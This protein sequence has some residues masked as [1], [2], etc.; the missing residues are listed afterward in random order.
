[1]R[2]QSDAALH[3]DVAFDFRRDTPEGKDPDTH[4]KRLRRYHQLL[5]SKRLPGGEIFE[6]EEY[7]R[8]LRYRSDRSG[9]TGL[10][11]SSDSVIPTFKWNDQIKR[12][13][14]REELDDF[15]AKGYT[16]GGMMIFP[17]EQIERKWTINQARGCTKEI[18]DRFD[19]TLE[20]IRRNYIREVS[21]LGDVLTRYTSF[22]DL[23]KD[24]R[25]YVEFFLLQDLVSSDCSRVRI[26]APF[27]DFRGSPIPATA[28][29]YRTYKSAALAFIEARNQR[30]RR[31]RGC[32]A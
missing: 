23:F 9:G 1:M 17:A 28:E 8:Y 25:G 3:I 32:A 20:C 29:D 11:L 31:S 24:F 30:I 26:A 2:S 13:I 6:L 12:L 22:F 10:V 14:S 27:D 19:L 5:W 4:S 21:P 7:G 18:R 16:I 15:S